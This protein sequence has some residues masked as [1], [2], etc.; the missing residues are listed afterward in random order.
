MLP[1]FVLQV[2]YSSM[3]VAVRLLGCFTTETSLS[4]YTSDTVP[5]ADPVFQEC[6]LSSSPLKVFCTHTPENV[7]ITLLHSC[8]VFRCL[9]DMAVD[10]Y[11]R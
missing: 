9:Y 1:H 4:D 3:L 8:F 10:H 5:S 2:Q 7:P 11:D 6:F